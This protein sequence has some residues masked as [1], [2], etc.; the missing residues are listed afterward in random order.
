MNCAV[1]EQPAGWRAPAII[2]ILVAAAVPGLP[3][4]ADAL[5]SVSIGSGASFGGPR[6][7]GTLLSSVLVAFFTAVFSFAIG[8]PAG[9]I[10]ALVWWTLKAMGK[11]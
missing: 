5:A 6:F 11:A 10:A 3:L 9:V 1:I 7:A 2:A 8:L 4:V